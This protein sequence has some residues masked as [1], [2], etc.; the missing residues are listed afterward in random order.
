MRRASY[1]RSKKSRVARIMG[2]GLIAVVVGIAML[3]ILKLYERIKKDV[4][5]PIF[6]FILAVVVAISMY[7]AAARGCTPE[8]LV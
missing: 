3:G 6:W 4:P 2:I 5:R 7:L 1:L 8:P